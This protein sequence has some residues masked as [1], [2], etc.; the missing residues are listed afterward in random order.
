M[1]SFAGTVT[2]GNA[3]TLREAAAVTPLDAAAGGDRRAV[4]DPDAVPRPAQRA[5]YLIPLTVRALAEVTGHDLDDAVRGDL[6]RTASA[7]FGR[8]T[9][10]Q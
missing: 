5:R 1:L 7:S 6:R 9:G 4:P 8:G 2:F 10:R 3:T